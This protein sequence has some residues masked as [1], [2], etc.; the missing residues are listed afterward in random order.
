MS[1]NRVVFAVFPIAAIAL[2]IYTMVTGKVD[3]VSIWL[4]LVCSAALF[5][6]Y[7]KTKY[8][9]RSDDDEA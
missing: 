1:H 6:E 5:V 9:R 8:Y 2:V 4:L 7:I 3:G